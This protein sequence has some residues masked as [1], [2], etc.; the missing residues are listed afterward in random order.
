M[1]DSVRDFLNNLRE[2][3]IFVN[4][5]LQGEFGSAAKTVGRFVVNSTIGMGGVV[6]VAG[7]WGVPFH[8]DD[9]GLT[10]GAWGLPE[11]PYLVVPILGPSTPR[12]LSGQVAEGFGDPAMPR[13]STVGITGHQH[14]F[15]DRLPGDVHP[16]IHHRDHLEGTLSFD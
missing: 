8:E 16:E 15:L 6:D 7:R 12:D 5:T 3:L 11:G 10:F 14:F 1:R 9:L 13:R 4:D 2:P